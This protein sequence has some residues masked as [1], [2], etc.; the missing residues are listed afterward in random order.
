MDERSIEVYGH[1]REAEQKLD[2]FVCGISGALFAYLGQHYIPHKLVC[3]ATI[4]EPLAL[5]FF[6]ISFYYGLIRIETAML[7]L[8]INHLILHAGEGAGKM[9]EALANQSSPAP[10]YNVEGGEVYNAAQIEE[11]RQHYLEEKEHL[12]TQLKTIQSK[13]RRHW[14]LRNWF[15]YLG[16]AAVFISKLS[17]PYVAAKT[18]QGVAVTNALTL[19]VTNKP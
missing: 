15:L 10:F 9:I 18:T 19:T 2:Y 16:F 6:A 7:C 14:N 12:E 1:Y 5:L 13:G 17:T 3:D 11:K 8:R 4:L